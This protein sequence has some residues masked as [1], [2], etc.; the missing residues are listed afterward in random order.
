MSLCVL[1]AFSSLKDFL[2][3][4]QMYGLISDWCFW[5]KLLFGKESHIM[6]AKICLYDVCFDLAIMGNEDDPDTPCL[7]HRLKPT[8]QILW[9]CEK[10]KINTF[11]SNI[12]EIICLKS[13][14]KLDVCYLGLM[15]EIG[16]NISFFKRIICLRNKSLICQF[17]KKRQSTED[18]NSGWEK[19]QRCW[20]I[21]SRACLF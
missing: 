11:K 10:G 2:Q 15:L 1:R 17:G 6:Q 4:L 21:T 14:S 18:W 13:P 19:K 5:R 9:F 8:E 7:F 12:K 3:L 20:L 16:F